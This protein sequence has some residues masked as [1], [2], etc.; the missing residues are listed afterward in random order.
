MQKH[1]CVIMSKIEATVVCKPSSGESSGEVCSQ[2]S[3][4]VYTESYKANWVFCAAKEYRMR[5]FLELL[6][7]FNCTHCRT[8]PTS[9]VL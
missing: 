3:V 9:K 2:R 6:N 4:R 5:W 1:V 8:K 7:V